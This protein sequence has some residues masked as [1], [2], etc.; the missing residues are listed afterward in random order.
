MQRGRA[1]G[2]IVLTIYR[3]QKT[4]RRREEQGAIMKKN[5]EEEGPWALQD[6]PAS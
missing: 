6:P 4:G 5:E 1:Q 3:G 2:K